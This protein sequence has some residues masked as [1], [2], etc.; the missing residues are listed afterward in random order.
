MKT[1]K[2]TLIFCLAI[3]SQVVLAGEWTHINLKSQGYDVKISYTKQWLPATIGA[4]GGSVSGRA[5]IDVYSS[6]P[7]L[8]EKVE[9][10]EASGRKHQSVKLNEDHSRHFWGQLVEGPSYAQHLYVGSTYVLKLTIDGRIV[11]MKFKAI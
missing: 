5:F 3:L 11:E 8:A 10:F 7:A 6:S 9:I 4:Q 2:A 1:L